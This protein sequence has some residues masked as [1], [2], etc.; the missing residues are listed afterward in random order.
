MSGIP[1][2]SALGARNADTSLW[3]KGVSNLTKKLSFEVCPVCPDICLSMY[4]IVFCVRLTARLFSKQGT[5]Y[6]HIIFKSFRQILWVY[7]G[8]SILMPKST[9]E[10]LRLSFY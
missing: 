8:G 4:V 2:C 3:R 6:H 9:N 5:V 7:P 1:T 10:D